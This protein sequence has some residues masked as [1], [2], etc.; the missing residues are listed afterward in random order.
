MYKVTHIPRYTY[1]DY[2]VWKDDWELIDGYP[3]SMSP[4]ASGEHQAVSGEIYFQIKS[5]IKEVKC[6]HTCFSYFELDWVIDNNTVVRPD[7]AI[8]C[9]NKVK[10]FINS[11]PQLIVEV[12]SK[13][14]VYH[15]RIVKKELYEIQKVQNYLIADPDTKTVEVFEMIDD[16]YQQLDK[17]EFSLQGQCKI[18]FDFSVIW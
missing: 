13:S 7:I 1:D 9:G 12:L 14:S 8:V 18:S 5:Q 10:K 15:D 16:K 3:Y 11:T 2:K 17:N 6:R 4:S